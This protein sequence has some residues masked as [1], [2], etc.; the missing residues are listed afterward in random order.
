MNI[1]SHDNRKL[2]CRMLGH[3]INFNYCRTGVDNLPCRK[4]FDCWFEI[5]DIADFMR[6]HYSPEQI[7]EILSEPKD[8]VTTIVDLIRQAQKRAEKGDGHGDI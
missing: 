3:E 2:R 4:I 8:K 6:Q 7:E 5:F 1:D